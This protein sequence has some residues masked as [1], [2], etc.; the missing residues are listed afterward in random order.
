MNSSP[1]DWASWSAPIHAT[2]MF[3]VRDGEILLI[4]KKRGLGAGKI[5]GP[6]GKIDPGETPLECA[7]RET[8]EELHIKV[9]RPRKMGEL[10]FAMSEVPDILCHVYLAHD[11]EG[12]PTETEEAKPFWCGLEDIPYERMWRDDVHWLPLML[13]H[14][15]FF[16][17]FVFDGEEV[18]WF[19]VEKDVFWKQ[20]R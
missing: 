1:I 19:D 10:H 17:R 13:D 4:E 14:R 3:V 20:E 5:N 18:A 7:V 16:G 11:F 12:Q 6:G 15:T 8:E 2:L 9:K